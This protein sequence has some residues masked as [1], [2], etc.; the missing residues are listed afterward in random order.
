MGC[1]SSIL[2]PNVLIQHLQE[3]GISTLNQIS[4]DAHTSIWQQS[5]K[6]AFQLGL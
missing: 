4:D 3:F 6:N 2:H 1:D 5:W